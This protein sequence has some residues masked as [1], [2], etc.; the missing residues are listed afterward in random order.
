M[1]ESAD[2]CANTMTH[3]AATVQTSKTE[4][5]NDPFLIAE[6]CCTSKTHVSDRLLNDD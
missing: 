1:A 4:A 3:V 6:Y 5:S 2:I